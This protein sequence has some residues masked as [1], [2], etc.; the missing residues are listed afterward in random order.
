MNFNEERLRDKAKPYIEGGRSGDW[1]HALRVVEWVKDLG[2]GR[3]DLYLL[4]TAGYLHDVGWSGVAPNDKIDLDSMKRLE[5]SANENSPRMAREILLSLQYA[6]PEILTVIRLIKAADKHKSEQED[7]EIVVDADNLSKLCLEHLLQKY[8]PE[9]FPKVLKLWKDEFPN[10]I[11]TEKGKE[12][13]PR[14]LREIE[15]KINQL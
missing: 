11:K 9:S 1:E 7:E 2:E 3:D 15:Q 10:R 13:F 14:L 4:I 8:Q 6:D 12:I 5:K